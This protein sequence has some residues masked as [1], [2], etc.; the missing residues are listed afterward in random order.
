MMKKNH[1]ICVHFADKKDRISCI[2]LVIMYFIAA[3]WILCSI[4]PIDSHSILLAG[5]LPPTFGYFSQLQLIYA[6]ISTMLLCKDLFNRRMR[7]EEIAQRVN[8][9]GWFASRVLLGIAVCLLPNLL[10]AVLM[11]P[12]LGQ[13]WHMAFLWMAIVV[14]EY[15]I[16]HAF[17]LLSVMCVGNVIS[18][19]VVYCVINIAALIIM[20]CAEWIYIPYLYGFQIDQYDF[21][22]FAPVVQLFFWIS[23]FLRLMAVALS[24]QNISAIISL[25]LKKMNYAM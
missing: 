22:L 15:L 8:E 20:W 14:V 21:F 16:F 23:G 19:I 17:A 24:A 9:K 4:I 10:I 12:A 3:L 11:I 13:S 2:M 1:S 5:A 25:C 7:K 6:C 18:A